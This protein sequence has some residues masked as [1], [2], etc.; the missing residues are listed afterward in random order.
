[1]TTVLEIQNK[2]K[3]FDAV[4]RTTSDSSQLQTTWKRL[5]S[6][7][8]GPEAASSF[9]RFY[10]EMRKSNTVKHSKG[11]KKASRR[12]AKQ[13]KGMMRKRKETARRQHG[14]AAPLGSM[15]IPG[16]PVRTFGTFPVELGTD[17]RSVQDLDVFWQSGHGPSA[18]SAYWPTVS[19]DMGSNKVPPQAGGGRSRKTRKQR[20][21]SLMDSLTMRSPFPFT[22]SVPPNLLQTASG[23][24]SGT[25]A[26]ASSNPVDPAWTLKSNSA[27]GPIN[28]SVVAP[29]NNPP[30]GLAT[31]SLWGSTM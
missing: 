15:M 27:G 13:A 30:G 20:G 11:S 28:P 9:A 2:L 4:A 7:R 3:E 25:P 21:G 6:Q 31:S 5:F 24:W 22:G 10:R 8:L 26:A 1:M 19:A 16:L 17:S 14:G 23:A 29:V 18:P 12:Q